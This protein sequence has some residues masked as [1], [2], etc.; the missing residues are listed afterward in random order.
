MAW[1]DYYVSVSLNRTNTD[2]IKKIMTSQDRKYD[3]VVTGLLDLND[4]LQKNFFKSTKVGSPH[5]H[6]KELNKLL[7]EIE[8]ERGE[9]H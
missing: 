4:F 2:R 1:K 3:D 7:V 8:K 5:E 6:I 9:M